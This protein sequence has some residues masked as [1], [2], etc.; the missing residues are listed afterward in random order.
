[1]LGLD[2]MTHGAI[3]GLI[4]KHYASHV[5]ALE[6]PKFTIMHFEHVGRYLCANYCKEGEKASK[7]YY[8][9]NRYWRA[10]S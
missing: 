4:Y 6:P 9:W 7:L 1:M 2:T 5:A 3:I 8:F 10:K